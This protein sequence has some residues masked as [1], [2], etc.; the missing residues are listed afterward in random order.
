MLFCSQ[1]KK[2]VDVFQIFHRTGSKLWECAVQ[3]TQYTVLLL[4]LSKQSNVVKKCCEV[5][6]LRLRVARTKGRVAVPNVSREYRH[7]LDGEGGSDPCLD[8]FGG[9]VHMH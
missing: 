1:K 7:C 6:E 8:F 5:A 2:Y 4:E 3:D 9:Y